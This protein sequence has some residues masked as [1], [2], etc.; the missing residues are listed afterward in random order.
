MSNT[1]PTMQTKLGVTGGIGSG[2]SVV[3]HI[4]RSCGI[5]VYDCDSN[6]K[7]LTASDPVIRDRLVSLLGSAI[8]DGDGRLNKSMLADYLFASDDH[9]RTVNGIIHPRVRTDIAHWASLQNSSL[10]GVESAIF[11]EARFTDVVDKI[12]MVSAPEDVRIARVVSRDNTT[13]DAVRHRISRQMSDEE[14]MRL[15]DFCIVNDGC[16]PLLP[17]VLQL[18]HRL[19]LK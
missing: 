18:M 14:K 7:R 19:M 16:R 6:S 10:V 11:F 12:L 2:K 15:S 17:Q 3:S 13:A 4:L 8:Y 9:V 5:P 1:R